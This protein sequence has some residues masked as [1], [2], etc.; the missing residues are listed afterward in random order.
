M[1]TASSSR[2][3]STSG[4]KDKDSMDVA[5]PATPAVNDQEFSPELLRFFYTRLFPY[6]AMF[7]WLSYG[8]DP[9]SEGG[10]VVRDFFSRREFSFTINDDIYIRYQSF[11]DAAEMEAAIQ[12]KQPHKIDIGAVFTMPPKDHHTVKAEAF[13]P[14]ERELIFD[15]DMTDYDDIRTCCTG[16]KICPK[17]WIFMTMAV[18][19]VDTALREDFGFQ[20][21]LWVYSGRRGVHCWVCDEDVRGLTNDGRSAVVEYLSLPRGNENNS[22]KGKNAGLTWPLHPSFARA[23]D[24]LEP[25]FEVG[26][27]GE[28]GQGVLDSENSWDTLL[29]SLPDE[30]L[31]LKLRREMRR[32]TTAEERWREIKT[33]LHAKTGNSGGGARR[34]SRGGSLGGG[35]RGGGG[36]YALELWKYEVV[37]KYCYPRLDVNVSKG[38]NH[39]LKSPFAVHPKTGRVCVPIDPVAIDDFDPFKVPTLKALAAQIDAY[40]A[41]HAQDEVARG[42]S[43]YK[44]TELKGAVELLEKCVVEPMALV[45]KKRA[46]ME[47]ERHAAMIGDF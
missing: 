36:M 22:G 25:M 40:D 24:I 35:G 6:Q 13:K 7:K 44:K 26:V 8:N 47:R 11:R 23:F 15:I 18:K 17:C 20:Q 45:M 2:R 12:K 9:D 14:V 42:V 21:L 1:S 41:E 28:E 4:T 43:D 46:R 16:A 27:L 37:F 33:Q 38:I 31:A 10:H 5:G 19:V 34:Q 32:L 39:L 3:T 29:D 30:D